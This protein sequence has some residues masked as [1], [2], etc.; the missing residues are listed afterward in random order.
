MKYG[1]KITDKNIEKIKEA[2][3]N[4]NGRARE[5]IGSYDDLMSAITLIKEKF[6]ISKKAFEDCKFQINSCPAEFYNAYYKKGTPKSTFYYI[7]MHSNNWYL[8][9]IQRE[10][11]TSKRI[12]V[13]NFTDKAK[14]EVI[15]NL[16]EF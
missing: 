12:Y 2:I 16:Y 11:C 8:Y 15:Y 9:D 14:D 13:V 3:R 7:Q 10:R 6:N 4:G 5:R 1:I